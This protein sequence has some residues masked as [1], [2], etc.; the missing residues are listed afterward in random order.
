M[1]IQSWKF[2]HYLQPAHAEGKSGEVSFSS[3]SPGVSTLT[4]FFTRQ[5]LKNQLDSTAFSFLA[6]LVL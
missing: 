4:P 3:E 1:F 5:N 2:S 6:E